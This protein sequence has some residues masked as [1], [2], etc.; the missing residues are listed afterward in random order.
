MDCRISAYVP[1]Y[2]AERYLKQTLLALSAQSHP[3]DEI[4]V[5]D[6]GSSDQSAEIARQ[7]PVRL[8]QHQRNRGLAA[9][10]NTAIQ[11]AQHEFLA[12]VDADVVIE[13]EW[14]GCLF[15]DINTDESIAGVGGRL[16]VVIGA[17]S[18]QNIDL[19]SP[20]NAA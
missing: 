1:C 10:R 18:P 11:C 15:A 16:V 4:L 14:L 8:I 17:I 13:P 7:F 3:P 6:D 5:I 20:L 19:K 12:A 9:A 2:N